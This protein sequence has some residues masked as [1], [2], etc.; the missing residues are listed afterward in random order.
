MLKKIQYGA[1]LLSFIFPVATHAALS[2]NGIPANA[3]SVA[4]CDASF[5]NPPSFGD[6]C[7]NGTEIGTFTLRNNTPVTFRINYIRLQDNDG[8]PGAAAV[9]VPSPANSC[10]SSLAAGATCNIS[11]ELLPLA[12]GTY[13]RVL[14]VGINTRQIEIDAPAITAVVG[15]CV[16]PG[17]TPPPGFTPTIPGTPLTL[18]RSSILGATTVTNTG[19]TIINGDLDLTPGS[20]VTGFPPGTIINGT[21]NINNGAATTTKIDAQAYFTALNGLACDFT[22]GA[23]TD[24]TTLSPMSCTGGVVRCF[25]STALMTGPVV[26]NG[27]AGDSCTFLIASTLTVSPGATMTTAGGIFNDNI[28]YAIGTSATLGTGSTL[29]GIIDASA[30]ISL[31]TGATLNGRAWALNGAVTLDTNSVNPSAP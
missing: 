22:F 3:L 1:V 16:T 28:N 30:S 17:P 6:L 31:L 23:G 27:V 29:Y 21:L 9:I 19:P 12:A 5:I 8:L 26:L 2:C 4:L 18:F 13:N 20:S 7:I 25:T 24:L 10:G 11:V 15:G 14:Q